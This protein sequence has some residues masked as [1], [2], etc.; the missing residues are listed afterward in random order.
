[1]NYSHRCVSTDGIRPS[2]PTLPPP[3]ISD[4]M[5]EEPDVLLKRAFSTSFLYEITSPSTTPEVPPETIICPSP[6]KSFPD[7][8]VLNDKR[9]PLSLSMSSLNLSL[10]R[11]HGLNNSREKLAKPIFLTSKNG[12][13][14]SRSQG[15]FYMDPDEEED[16]ETELVAFSPPNRGMTPLGKSIDEMFEKQVDTGSNEEDTIMGNEALDNECES[17]SYNAEKSPL[18]DACAELLEIVNSP[19]LLDINDLLSPYTE[20]T[21]Q[22]WLKD[23]MSITA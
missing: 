16:D 21:L 23:R 18:A 11:L 5:N 19:P 22:Y 6:R 2:R 13:P 20:E 7:V 4:L 12:V 14:S 1:M 9:L 15:M 17:S 3:I 10:N 8:T